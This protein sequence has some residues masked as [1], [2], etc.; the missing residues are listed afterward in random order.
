MN[1]GKCKMTDA[2][3]ERLRAMKEHNILEINF[4][5]AYILDSLLDICDVPFCSI[6]AIY[7]DNYHVIDSAGVKTDEIFPRNGSCTEYVHKKNEFC[8]LPNVQEE[9]EIVDCAKVLNGS[10][11]VFYAGI[12]IC[13]SDGFALGVLNIVD[14]KSKELTEKQRHLFNMASLRIAK[15]IIEKRQEQRLLHFDK[16]FSKSKDIMGVIRFDGEIVNINP[17]FY[18]L[19]EYSEYEVIQNN[20]LN[21]I[22]PDHLDDAKSLLGRL[23]AGSSQLNYTIPA[24][25]KSNAVK[26]IEWTSTSEPSTELIYFIGR[27]I[28]SIEEQS[29]LLKKS[30]DRFRTFFENS[31]VSLF[32]HDM[33]L[34]IISANKHAAAFVGVAREDLVGYSLARL[35][36]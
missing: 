17:A 19:L 5:F 6:A 4:D 25:A 20:I 33:Q 31:Q 2:E 12:P 8:E 34:N 32:I 21:F 14:F 30:E 10:D 7:K 36:S 23:H 26:C 22:H 29:L 24:V 35:L 1:K 9:D 27:D 13:D 28:T 18:E 15:E 3:K 16:M 11:I